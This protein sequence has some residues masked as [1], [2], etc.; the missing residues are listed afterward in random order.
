CFVGS[1][2][3]F[4]YNKYKESQVRGEVTA[5]S[6]RLLQNASE[7]KT[8]L[9]Q[10]LSDY[11]RYRQSGAEMELARYNQNKTKADGLIKRILSSAST[12]AQKQKAAI[13]Q[14]NFAILLVEVESQKPG[15]LAVSL[16]VSKN[17]SLLL[18]SIDGFIE[19]EEEIFERRL[20][21]LI[22]LNKNFY[23]A[24]VV[25]TFGA[26]ALLMYMNY[27]LLM[28]QNRQAV[29]QKKLELMK[30][31]QAQSFQATRD[32]L[33]EWKFQ[34]GDSNHAMYWS[35]R[36]KE[37][38]GY[39]DDE[40]TASAETLEQLMHPDDREKFWHKL[41]KH[42]RGQADELSAIFRWRHKDGHWVWINARGAAIFNEL[43]E[44]IK[45]VGI[46]TDVTKLK[47][48]ELQ[49]AKSKDEAEKANAAKSDF[50]AHMSHEIRTPLTAVTGVAEI[51][52]M[53]KSKFDEKSQK[54]MEALNASSVGLRDLINDILDFSKIESGKI[55]LE[56][57]EIDIRDFFE[58]IVSIISVRSSEKNLFFE[59]NYSE[60]DGLKIHGDKTRLRQILINLIGNAV[61]FTH[62]GNVR[63]HAYSVQVNN[64]EM[65][66]VDVSDTG[67]GIADDQMGYIFES[68]RQADASVS[69]K[70]GGT[71]L[72]LPIA[73]HL[74][75][76]MGGD[77][78]VSSKQGEGSL[79]TL[80]IPL[81]RYR[82][83]HQ[84][85]DPVASYN[86]NLKPDEKILVVEDYEGNI[87][88]ITHI[89]DEMKIKYDLGRTGLEGLKLWDENDYKLI[90]M[91][92]QMPEM[93]GISAVKHIRNKEKE[94]ELQPIPIIA[95][96]AHAFSE[97]RQKCLN[98]GFSE[99]LPK[100][101][102]KQGLFEKISLLLK[103]A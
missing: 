37:M 22:S 93:D 25:G 71:G 38:I 5:S 21:S 83:A 15:D 53:Q 9:F 26:F 81:I 10:M 72:G 90:L 39:T 97:D 2:G 52:N 43:N 59:C 67:I 86:V 35:P 57:K 29:M 91:D 54:L 11:R 20:E 78:I 69:R 34:P 17:L 98:A 32:G 70:Y 33:F 85:S 8:A 102:T 4:S 73:R 99:Y 87:A 47:E 92:I 96:T 24:L 1:I 61:K 36:L 7:V 56:D 79:F 94:S 40:L 88:F 55:A 13:I 76:L 27:S 84:E 82:E 62:K 28:A 6:H 66:R 103:A 30:E 89:L 12:S 60:I 44:P 23:V 18:G 77:I 14:E 101:L 75:R 19:A 74:A 50:L 80:Q 31:R 49:L 95:M 42:L 3:I 100:P 16:S 46:H 41:H 58:N 45:L 68:F 64:I 48:Y 51:L 63:V 65:L